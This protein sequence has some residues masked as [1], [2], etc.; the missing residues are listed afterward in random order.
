MLSSGGH[1]G[2]HVSLICV[3][4]VYRWLIFLCKKMEDYAIAPRFL[5]NDFCSLILITVLVQSVRIGSALRFRSTQEFERSR[6]I[7]FFHQ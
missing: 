4:F 3:F 5:L 6:F 1:S 2:P 7:S